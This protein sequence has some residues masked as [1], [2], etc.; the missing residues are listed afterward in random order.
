MKVKEE[1]HLKSAISIIPFLQG[2]RR[3]AK[4]AVYLLVKYYLSFSVFMLRSLGWQKAL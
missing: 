2:S 4:I 3:S 1:A